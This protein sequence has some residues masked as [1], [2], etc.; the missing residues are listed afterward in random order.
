[1]V[2][3]YGG[4]VVHPYLGRIVLKKLNGSGAVSVGTQIVVPHAAAMPRNPVN[5][6]YYTGVNSSGFTSGNNEGKRTPSCTIT[7]LAQNSFL[8]ANNINSFIMTLNGNGDTDTWSILLDDLYNP[9]VYDGAKCASIQI[10]QQSMGGP[11]AL[12]MAFLC[13]YG[14]SQNPGTLY[15]LTT[16]SST[17]IQ[18]G[19]TMDVT[20][21]QYAGTADLV[22]S[23]AVD[24]V[25]PQGYVMYDD[26]TFF[27]NGIASGMFGGDVTISQSTKYT[28]TPGTSITIN[29]GSTGNGIS[30]AGLVLL[31][32]F[33]QD[34]TMAPRTRVSQY[35]LYDSASGGNPF[36]I[37][38][39]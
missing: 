31:N 21:V 18:A 33:I 35:S 9:L 32:E 4:S 10:R 15:P 38:A 19:Q 7:T 8:T 16:F 25:R 2:Y 12:S 20:Q 1:M 36:V 13:Q 17:T 34:M 23:L 26:G 37:T 3:D 5:N 22:Q 28:A 30:C 6:S 24:L 27:A 29:I 11:I 39:L 14:D